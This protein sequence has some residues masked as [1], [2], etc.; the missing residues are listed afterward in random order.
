M[1]STYVGGFPLQVLHFR[2]SQKQRLDTTLT[3]ELLLKCVLYRI[4]YF[5][6]GGIG[7]SQFLHYLQ[8]NGVTSPNGIDESVDILQG[9]LVVR[10]AP[11]PLEALRGD[12]RASGPAEQHPLGEA[13]C[14]AV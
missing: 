12:A 8:R 9:E 7:V 13:T 2:Q 4:Q 11:M 5:L 1:L 3:I 10:H 6:T 14:I